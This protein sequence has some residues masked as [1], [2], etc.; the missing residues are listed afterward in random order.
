MKS[1]NNCYSFP[2]NN[3]V[4]DLFSFEENTDFTDNQQNNIDIKDISKK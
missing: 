1:E 3:I 2:T 4:C